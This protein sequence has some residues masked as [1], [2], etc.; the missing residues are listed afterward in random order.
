MA[1]QNLRSRFFP[2]TWAWQ[3]YA[4]EPYSCLV[5]DPDRCTPEARVRL[6]DPFPS[7]SKDAA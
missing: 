7:W 1:D 2:V 5:G 3:D 6:A 4:F